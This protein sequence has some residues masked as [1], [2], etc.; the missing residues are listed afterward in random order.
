MRYR[1]KQNIIGV[2]KPEVTATTI[3]TIKSRYWSAFEIGVQ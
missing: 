3:I 1:N 2:A